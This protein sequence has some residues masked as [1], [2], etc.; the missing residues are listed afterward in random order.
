MDLADA[1]RT[2]SRLLGQGEVA[3]I[4]LD[5]RDLPQWLTA[6]RRPDALLDEALVLLQRRRRERVSRR[7]DPLRE[8]LAERDINAAE[9]P[10][11]DLAAQLPELALG[12]FARALDRTVR[13]LGLA[14]QRVAADGHDQLPRPRL[15]FSH[16]PTHRPIWRPGATYWILNTCRHD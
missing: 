3:P 10:A 12:L 13:V 7:V 14:R 8:Q 5:G 9:P 4:Q 6:E 11:L 2:E 16:V 1:G 15:A